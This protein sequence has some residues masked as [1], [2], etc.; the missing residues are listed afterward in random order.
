MNIID[1]KNPSTTDLEFGLNMKGLLILR[2][3][4]D[5]HRGALLLVPQ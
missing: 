5:V 4:V 2:K 1:I 3:S